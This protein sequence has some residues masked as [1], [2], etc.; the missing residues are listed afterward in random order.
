[1]FM[2]YM[3]YTDDACMQM[4]TPGQKDRMWA[5]L[6]S[7][8]ARAVITSSQGCSTPT[9]ACGTPTNLVSS[10][11]AQTLLP[12]SWSKVPDATSY[13]LQYKI[14]SAPAI[15]LLADLRLPLTT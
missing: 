8:G 5:V 2:N 12:I 4:F 13:A 10:N 1:M 14:S 3:D 7:G 9:G 15:Q 11:I 6:Q